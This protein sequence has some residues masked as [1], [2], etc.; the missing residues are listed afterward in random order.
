MRRTSS[1]LSFGWPKEELPQTSRRTS[2][3]PGAPPRGEDPIG[4]CT[5]RGDAVVGA[6]WPGAATISRDVRVDAGSFPGD[7]DPARSSTSARCELAQRRVEAHSFDL[8]LAH[9]ALEVRRYPR[10]GAYADAL[11]PP[12]P[13]RSSCFHV[14]ARVREGAA[15]SPDCV[16]PAD[17]FEHRSSVTRKSVCRAAGIVAVRLGF[18]VRSA[19]RRPD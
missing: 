6:R 4:A 7:A 12:R 8:P 3:G 1:V 9:S 13:P 15:Q 16:S 19:E 10:N 5:R 18:G 17:R 2:S 11:Q 14:L